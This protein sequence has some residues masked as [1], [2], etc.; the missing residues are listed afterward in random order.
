MKI[1]KPI[2]LALLLSILF[3]CSVN[4]YQKMG[5][6]ISDNFYGKI[7]F[8]TIKNIIILPVELDGVKKNFLFDTG[9][10]L[11]SIQRD[12]VFGESLQIGSP[13][14]SPTKSGSEIVKSLKIGGINFVNTFATNINMIGINEQIPNFG[15]IIGQSIISK[16][17]WLINYPKKTIEISDKN[18]AKDTF[19]TLEIDIKNERYYTQFSIDGKIEKGLIDLGA[20]SEFILTKESIISE[21]L[22]SKY[23]FKEVQRPRTSLGITENI[24]ELRGIIPLIK[25][26]E[27]EFENVEVT[28]GDSR[29]IR[30]GASFFK[31][32]QFYIDNS[33]R[34]IKLKK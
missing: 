28:I 30:I 3:S 15:G 16:A 22:M 11:N 12:S 31:E 14:G 32:C 24:V 10:E 4:K 2:L 6:V 21:Y 19:K 25:L 17:N 18:L 23:E 13:T 34:S 5:T 7:E 20:S 8:T 1:L 29:N 26:G 9:N 33:S 27:I